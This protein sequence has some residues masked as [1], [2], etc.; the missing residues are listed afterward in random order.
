MTLSKRE[1]V[2]V[3]VL[4]I[5]AIFALGFYF[6]VMP[7][8]NHMNET[9]QAL[10]D[11]K[12]NVMVSEVEAQQAAS[13]QEQLD[14]KNKEAEAAGTAFFDPL[15]QEQ[16]EY[17]FGELADKSNLK[18]Q[19]ISL[20]PVQETQA[21]YAPEQNGMPIT[22][23]AAMPSTMP[24]DPAAMPSTAPM[25]DIASVPSAAPADVSAEAIAAGN[26]TNAIFVSAVVYGEYAQIQGFLQSVYENPY[27][28][29]IDN[30][31]ISQAQD[32]GYAMNITLHVFGISKLKPA[33]AHEFSQPSGQSVLMK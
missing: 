16:A 17:W 11:L 26:K 13:M 6:V 32:G 1:I 23:P 8:M 5:V 21:A 20:S 30:I 2:L 25:A 9:A 33:P 7:T 28:V 10:E 3:F 29:V 22:D 15:H 14:A 19:S 12:N 31:V 18:V 24:I 4:V 27:A